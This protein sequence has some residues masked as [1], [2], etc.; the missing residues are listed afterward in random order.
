MN[1][2]SALFGGGLVLL[3]LGSVAY[4]GLGAL[5][6]WRWR[7][8]SPFPT[9]H[10][11]TTPPLT[12][13]RPLKA[14]VPRLR[15]NLLTLLEAMRAEDQLIIGVEPDSPEMEICRAVQMA[16]PTRKICLV[17]TQPGFA[18]N[19]KINKLI[20]MTPEAL[21]SDWVLSD[22]EAVI[23]ANW[24]ET[25]RHQWIASGANAFTSGYR[26]RGHRSW[27]E[28]LDV[29]AVLLE[30]WPGLAFVQQFGR[31]RFT[32]GAC[33]GFRRNDI[34]SIGGWSA[35]GDCLAE[36][37]QIGA[38]LVA[39]G[40]V[41]QLSRLLVTLETDPL[42]WL[43]YW[44]HQRRVAVTYRVCNPRGFAGKSLTNGLVAGIGL[45]VGASLGYWNPSAAWGLAVAVQIAR[46]ICFCS[47]R[48]S[49]GFSLQWLF[50]TMLVAGATE[51]LCAVGAW[52]H[53]CIWWAGKRWRIS[54]SGRLNPDPK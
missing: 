44:R 52:L 1:I 14:G 3:E 24:L 46:W 38:A 34:E 19:P 29:A 51:C 37:Y 17:G 26:M 27:P 47:L 43:A 36:D 2:T 4:A 41:V 10:Q 13:L 49:L 9:A 12:L 30:L 20:Q 42:D 5:I 8:P 15:E 11:P 25:F 6:L 28:C 48:K 31:L 45:G 18:L 39:D 53:P 32:L 35:F 22:S 33:T 21:H 7:S 40:K 54:S 50:P 23:D 16:S